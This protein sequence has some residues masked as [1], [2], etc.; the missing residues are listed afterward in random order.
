M[1]FVA[2]VGVDS[3]ACTRNAPC[4][5]IPFVLAKPQPQYKTIHILGGTYA[6]GAST[7]E[8]SQAAYIEGSNPIITASVNGPVFHFQ[9][10]LGM[11]VLNDVTV[12]GGNTP[13]NNPAITV[14]GAT[15]QIYGATIKRGVRMMSGNVSIS[16]STFTDP[17]VAVSGVDCT[18]G[19]VSID[20]SSFTASK[21]TS[22]GCTL[23]LSRSRFNESTDSCFLASGGK[24][25]IENNLFNAQS[26]LLDCG[27]VDAALAGSTVRFNTFANLSDLVADGRALS[28]DASLDVTSNIFAWG[29]TAPHGPTT[30]APKYSLYDTANT[31][32]VPPTSFSGNAST[33]FV[34]KSAM[35]FHL[36]PNSPAIGMA[37]TGLTVTTDLDGNPRPSPDGSTPDV[38]AYE[39]P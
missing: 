36:A 39:A 19:T 37:Q 34:N 3:G 13:S 6:I 17:T 11:G 35:D 5:T 12:V 26:E 14:D 22:T 8:I 2:N 28:C 30:C 20:T 9:F 32:A 23:T 7:L 4:A 25:V 38:G 27:E 18:S 29:S 31:T 1:F 10:S 33:F 15:V 24:V 21:I 16:K